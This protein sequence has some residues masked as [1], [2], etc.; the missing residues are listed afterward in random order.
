MPAMDE[1]RAISR[2][3][4]LTT[5]LASALVVLATA[6]P[7][8][9]GNT[10]PPGNGEADQYAETVPGAGGNETPDGSQQPDDVLPSSQV[11]DLEDAGANGAGLAA[12]IAATAP[13]GK[14]GAGASGGGGSGSGSERG[15]GSGS[16][17]AGV[18]PVAAQTTIPSEDGL[19]AALW[20]IVALAAAGG[21]GFAAWRR[22]GQPR[23]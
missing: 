4:I 8:W 7:A 1:M 14:S 9:A 13:G 12:F 11:D 22:W 18:P 15:D 16:G 20:V 3:D 23:A 21:L 5:L 2:H 10:V 17:E 19:G 6:A